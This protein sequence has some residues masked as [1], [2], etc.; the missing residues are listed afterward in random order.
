MAELTYQT[1]LRRA[2][3][4]EARLEASTKTERELRVE[5]ASARKDL[6]TLRKAGD[7]TEATQRASLQ[8]F[9]EVVARLSV[10]EQERDTLRQSLN[11]RT[12]EFVGKVSG[13][14]RTFLQNSWLTHQRWPG[15]KIGNRIAHHLCQCCYEKSRNRCA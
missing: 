6:A 1:K 7:D 4:L 3:D 5:L 9:D 15:A 11:T 10:V 2:H 13:L 8:S 12:H 14:K